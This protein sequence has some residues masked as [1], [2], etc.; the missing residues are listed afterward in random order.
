MALAAALVHAVWNQ[1][2]AGSANPAARSA[3]GMLVACVV[4]VPLAVPGW[5]WEPEVWPLA[6]ASAACELA[7]FVALSAAYR[8]APLGVVYPVARGSAPVLV[9][10][11][12]WLTLGQAVAWYA[13]VG[14]ALVV[15][16]VLLVRGPGRDVRLRHVLLAVGI[17]ACIAAYTLLDSL[18]LEHASPVALLVVV[19]GATALVQ[20]GAIASRT[21]VGTLLDATLR[22]PDAWRT[23][24]AGFGILGAYG[25]VLLALTESPAAPVAAVRETSVVMVVLLLALTGRERLTATRLAGAGAVAAGVALVVL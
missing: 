10:L 7:Y 14:V 16:G 4:A 6:A 19:L 18:A 5:R 3:V 20:A 9:L 22:G 1:V 15:A 24:V 13:A 17:G 23:L 11:V 12:G 8:V 25:L 2:L 21:G